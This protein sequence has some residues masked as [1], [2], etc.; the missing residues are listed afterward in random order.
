MNKTLL[1]H[2]LKKGFW[3]GSL[4]FILIAAFMAYFFRNPRRSIPLEPGIVIAPA[5]G[6]VTIARQ[7][8]SENPEALVSIFLSPFD[9]HINR[10]PIA[11]E[12]VDI[13]TRKASS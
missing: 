11:G 2:I 8:T 4:L 6:K 9:V 13:A 3:I 7:A 12:I 10:A 1:S 5:D